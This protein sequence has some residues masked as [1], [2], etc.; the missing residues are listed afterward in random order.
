MFFSLISNH[1]R[2]LGHVSWNDIIGNS[3]EVSSVSK[4]II[5]VAHSRR[6]QSSFIHFLKMDV[7][8]SNKVIHDWVAN[9]E[10]LGTVITLNR[11]ISDRLS[12]S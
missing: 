11:T 8:P 3:N 1:A 9:F 5:S 2:I 10:R 7:I 6:F 12:H 4:I